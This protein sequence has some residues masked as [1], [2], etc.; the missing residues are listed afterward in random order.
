[1]I[2]KYRPQ[3]KTYFIAS[4]SHYYATLEYIKE[5]KKKKRKREKNVY[6]L[7]HTHMHTEMR[8]NLK[9]STIEA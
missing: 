6:I 2:G 3:M 8:N 1:M 9:V 7:T 5:D 4:D